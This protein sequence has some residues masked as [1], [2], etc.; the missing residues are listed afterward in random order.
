M[1]G[2]YKP[3]PGGPEAVALRRA[4]RTAPGGYRGETARAAH[5][6]MADHIAGQAIVIAGGWTAK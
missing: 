3:H 6:G 1:W 2:V 4:L 5:P